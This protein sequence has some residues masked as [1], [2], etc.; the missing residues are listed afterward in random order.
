VGLNLWRGLLQWFGG[1][2]II[3]VAMVFLPELRVGGM[4]I[5][6]SEAF[7]TMGK[8]LPRATEIAARISVIYLGLTIAC[9]LTYAALGMP[10][11]DALVH[12]LTTCPRAAS[13]TTTRP[14]A[15][16]QGALEYAGIRLHDP[17]E[18]S[19]RALHPVRRRHR[20]AASAATARSGL[21]RHDRADRSG[22]ALYRVVAKGTGVE[23]GFR[24]ALFNVTSIISGTGYASADYQLWGGWRW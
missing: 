7:D 18:P 4:Q 21:S 5:F 10:G 2:G 16:I 24:E 23:H 17:R 15:S 12:A 22:L 14:S 8:I 13:P 6:R 11:F 1:I 19:L 20:A 9:G 3:V